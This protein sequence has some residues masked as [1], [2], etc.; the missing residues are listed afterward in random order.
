MYTPPGLKEDFRRCFKQL[1]PDIV[2]I[3]YA[4]WAELAS[5]EEF[6]KALRLIDTHDLVSLNLSMR[7]QFGARLSA[8]PLDPAILNEHFFCGN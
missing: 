1:N 3:N 7:R 4:Y 6:A 2:L 5:G 8:R